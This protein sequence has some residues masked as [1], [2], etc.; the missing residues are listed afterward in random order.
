MPKIFI[1]GLTFSELHKSQRNYSQVLKIEGKVKKFSIF[2]DLFV[3]ELPRQLGEGGGAFA[4][5]TWVPTTLSLDGTGEGASGGKLARWAA[6]RRRSG[7]CER[8][9]NGSLLELQLTQ[10]ACNRAKRSVNQVLGKRRIEG[11]SRGNSCLSYCQGLN[12]DLKT[13]DLW[14]GWVNG[15]RMAKRCHYKLNGA[16]S[17]KSSFQ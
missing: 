12:V 14:S 16:Y 15:V 6:P 9:V 5:E 17:H 11:Y 4:K 3:T 1:L 8:R 7:L 13:A 10:E 2:D